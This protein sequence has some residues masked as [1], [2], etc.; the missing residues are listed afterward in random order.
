MA[1]DAHEKSHCNH[2]LC[3]MS[4]WLLRRHKYLGARLELLSL[5]RRIVQAPA[6]AP[7]PAPVPVHVLMLALISY[8][9]VAASS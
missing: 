1:D 3:F 8:S 9:S 7:A 4:E 6:P 5:V 2:D